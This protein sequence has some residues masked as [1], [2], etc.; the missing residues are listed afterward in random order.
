MK[1]PLRNEK[2]SYQQTKTTCPT[3]VLYMEYKKDSQVLV[4]KT[5]QTKPYNDPIRREMNRKIIKADIKQQTNIS[6]DTQHH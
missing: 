3:K 1:N 5:K 6:K 2:T 4:V